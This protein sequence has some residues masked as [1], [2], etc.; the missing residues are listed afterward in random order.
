MV[1]N[2]RGI[3]RL[4]LERRPGVLHVLDPFKVTLADALEKVR[5]I[6]DLDFPVLILGSTDYERFEAQMT[7]YIDA[8]KDA[9][10]I[11]VVLHF[12]PRPGHGLPFTRN[13]D[14]IFCPALLNS[15]R[16]YMVWQSFLDTLNA[17]HARGIAPAETPELIFSAALTFGADRRSYEAMQTHPMPEDG[18]GLWLFLEIVRRMGL[19]QSYLYSRHQQVPPEICAL[20]RE[21]TPSDHLVFV[22][23]GMRSREQVE[24]YIDAGAD[25]VVFGSALEHPGW[26]E[27]L[28][29]IVC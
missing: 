2:D 8:L 20:F 21:H 17:F 26:R 7:P 25:Y 9:V 15:A 14:A 28:K 13:A 22:S 24:R 10:G 4:L 27:S 11:P 19:D 23:G 3:R 6:A 5:V 12:P 29:R 16:P 1:T 18:E